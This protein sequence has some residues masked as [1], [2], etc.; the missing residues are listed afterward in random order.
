MHNSWFV[1]IVQCSDGTFYTGITTDVERRV[2]EHNSHNQ[3]GSRYVRSRRPAEL[4]YCESCPDRSAAS[5]REYA[6]RKMS[7]SQKLA[8]I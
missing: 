2:R 8:L 7:R 3:K 6:V 5:R 4:V 1:Y